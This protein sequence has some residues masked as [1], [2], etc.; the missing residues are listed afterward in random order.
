MPA[1]FKPL[2]VMDVWEHIFMRDYR[3]TERG[4][5]LDAFFRN[6]DWQ[7][8]ERRLVEPMAIR[9]RSRR[10]KRGQGRRRLRG[11]RLRPV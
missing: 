5:Y 8:V 4:R 10:L 3:A 7:V 6:V 2:V 9:P 11:R 1:G